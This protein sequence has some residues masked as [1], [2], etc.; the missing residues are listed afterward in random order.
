VDELM[1]SKGV[2][3][4][5]DVSAMRTDSRHVLVQLGMN[6]RQNVARVVGCRLILAISICVSLAGVTLCMCKPW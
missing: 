6:G 4:K 5:G 2:K 1:S 3:M